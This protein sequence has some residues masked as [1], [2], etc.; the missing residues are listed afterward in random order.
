MTDPP[1]DFDERF[2]LSQ[3]IEEVRRELQLRE[4][5]Y[6]NMVRKG[7]MRP[8]IADYHMDRMRAVLRTLEKLAEVNNG[9]G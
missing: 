2:S 3:Q 5:V 6:P 7:Q 4:K 9:P 8:S 1:Q